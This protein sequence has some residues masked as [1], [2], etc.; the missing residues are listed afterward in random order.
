MFAAE[1]WRK[2]DGII[3]TSV[4]P[5]RAYPAQSIRDGLIKTPDIKKLSNSNNYKPNATYNPYEELTRD[6]NDLPF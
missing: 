3:G 1:E 2:E 4:K 6:D 5:L